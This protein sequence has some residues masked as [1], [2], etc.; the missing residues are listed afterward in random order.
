[1]LKDTYDSLNM[2][3]IQNLEKIE[4][5]LLPSLFNYGD[6]KLFLTASDAVKCFHCVPNVKMHFH[7][8][9]HQK[10]LRRQ[11]LARMRGDFGRYEQPVIE[12]EVPVL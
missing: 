2:S 12:A 1:M 7:E 8:I 4:D 9:S 3:Q 6:I 10:E 11:G 5:G